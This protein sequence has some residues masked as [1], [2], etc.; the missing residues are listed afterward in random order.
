MKQV[1]RVLKNDAKSKVA[2]LRVNSYSDLQFCYDTLNEVSRSFAMVIQDLPVDLKDAICVFYLILRALDTIEDDMSLEREEKLGILKDFHLKCGDETFFLEN[3]GDKEAY[4]KLLQSYPRVSRVYNGLSTDYQ[5]II[6]NISFEMSRG[7]QFF[8]EK[9]VDTKK[10]YDLYCHYVAGLVGQGL[11]DIFLA[12][13]LES[14][15][16]LRDKKISNSM[17]LFLQ[18]TNITRDFY[19]DIEEGR[20]FWP[21]EIWSIYTE[22]LKTLKIKSPKS[23]AC[24]NKMVENAFDHVSDCISYLEALE[25]DKVFRF[26]AIPQLMAIGTLS[27]IYNEHQALV[28]NI[29]M[30]KQ[31]TMR[32]FSSVN[33][34]KDFVEN[35]LIFLNRIHLKESDVAFSVQIRSLKL[36]LQKKLA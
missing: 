35:A 3:V 28:E 1:L 12:S 32:I 27:L 10:D 19:E 11:S 4:V 20:I 23:V 22:D 24:L 5:Q 7:M 31:E 13:S 2:K 17:G 25:N 18:K 30:D 8:I 6:R 21:R 26:C 36:E 29:K 34:M 14:N 9:E 16:L 15:D 33:N